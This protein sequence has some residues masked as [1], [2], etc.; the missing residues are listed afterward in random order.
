MRLMMPTSR[1]RRSPPGESAAPARGQP[2]RAASDGAQGSPRRAGGSGPTA[3]PAP[4]ALRSR[5]GPS[6]G[7][8]IRQMAGHPTRRKKPNPPRPG[9]RGPARV[10]AGPPLSRPDLRAAPRRYVNIPGNDSPVRPWW[11]RY[12][13]ADPCGLDV[14]GVGECHPPRCSTGRI[15]RLPRLNEVQA[16]LAASRALAP[17]NP[18]L[19]EENLRAYIV[20]LSAAL[21]GVLP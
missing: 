6:I 18:R 5:L 3:D 13:T 16:Q 7:T 15:E 9:E 19:S 4:T 21:P 8:F 20:L 17:P 11:I 14:R 10:P 1:Q 2:G 12:H